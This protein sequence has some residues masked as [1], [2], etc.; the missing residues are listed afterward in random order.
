VD[1]PKVPDTAIFK[2][3]SDFSIYFGGSPKISTRYITVTY[4]TTLG[5]CIDTFGTALT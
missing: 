3:F 4:A 5:R 1:L 2:K